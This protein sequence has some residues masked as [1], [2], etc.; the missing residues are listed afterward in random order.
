MP[1]TAS[2]DESQATY[3]DEYY[4]NLASQE[5]VYLDEVE[6]R[7]IEVLVAALPVPDPE[8]TSDSA[9]VRDGAERRR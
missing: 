5:Q 6:A 2:S 7:L 1:K 8:N 4:E 3:T 9:T